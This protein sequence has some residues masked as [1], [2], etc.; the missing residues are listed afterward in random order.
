MSP[1]LLWH[2]AY[3]HPGKE[4]P[5]RPCCCPRHKICTP[6]GCRLPSIRASPSDTFHPSSTAAKA[7]HPPGRCTSSDGAGL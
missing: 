3:H 2:P 4:F 1:P 7:P 6:R 5:D